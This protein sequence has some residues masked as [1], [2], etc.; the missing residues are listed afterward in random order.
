VLLRAWATIRGQKPREIFD[1]IFDAD[2]RAKWDTVLAG[3]RVVEDIDDE[4]DVIHFIIKVFPLLIKY[5][6]VLRLP[7]VLLKE[8]F[9]KRDNIN[10]I[11]QRKE[12]VLL[13]SKAQH[14]HQSLHLRIEL[15][16]KHILLGIL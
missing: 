11:I 14:I 10:M 6:H 13:V 12:Q 7:L 3:F 2:S 16:V 4:T 1:Q 15:E 9:Y 5:A 8:I